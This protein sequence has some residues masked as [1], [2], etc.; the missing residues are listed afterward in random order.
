MTG[1]PARGFRDHFILGV[2]SEAEMPGEKFEVGRRHA[3][4]WR[5]AE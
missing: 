1:R 4:E 5:V 3:I 2:K